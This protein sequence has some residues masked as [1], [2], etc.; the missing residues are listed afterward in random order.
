MHFDDR[1]ATVLRS[2][3]D[4]A[5]TSRIQ[6]RQLIDL[7][8]TCP[9]EARGE[10]LE[11]AYDRAA[12]LAAAI[13]EAERVGIIADPA[14]RLRSPRLVATLAA[15]GAPLAAAALRHARLEPEQWLDLI[16][17]LPPMARNLLRERRDLSPDVALLLTRL[18][19]HDRGL[20]PAESVTQDESLPE[21]SEGIGAIVR[22]IEAFRRTRQPGEILPAGD[23]PRLPLGEDHVLR[24]PTQLRAFD[25]ATDQLGRVNWADPGALAMVFGLALPAQ[26]RSGALAAAL[27]RRQP[28]RALRLV[29]EGAAAI[30]GEWQ[31]DATPWFDPET[32]SFTGYRGRLR[33]PAPQ[34]ALAVAAVPTDSEADRIRQL[35]HE[36]R[37]PVNAIQGFAEIIQQQL[38]GP[39][40]HEYRALAANIAADSARML[41]GFDELDRL[42]RLD[43]GALVPEAGEADL[44]QIV[45][46]TI[47]QLEAHTR[48]R[49][50]GFA[51]RSDEGVMGCALAPAEAE[52]LVWRLLATLAGVAAPG[53]VIKLRLRRKEG[54]IR[55]SI[56]LPATLAAMD[57]DALFHASSGGQMHALTAGMFG[58]GFTLRLVRAEAKAAGGSLKRDDEKLRLTLP[59]LTRAEPG[60]SDTAARL[61]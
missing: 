6:F 22:R 53:E 61:A 9:A 43:T 45:S 35:L 39:T 21:P 42:A 17:A 51:L 8:G 25:F 15:S 16:P 40:P 48:P 26:E 34:A 10:A 57:G 59:D 56:A 33:R 60:H 58:T 54:R 50:S 12:E 7:L 52:R 44:G 47:A 23:A 29:L 37:T 31:L 38:F 4:G 11:A 5:V 20:P 1:L 49:Q 32:G 28:L 14:L 41:A 18:G 27:R 2:R 36:L 19:A 30:S 46:A 24:L 55:L 3:A 13:P